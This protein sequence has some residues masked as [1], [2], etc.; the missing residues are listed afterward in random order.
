MF[1]FFGDVPNPHHANKAT[2]SLLASSSAMA[3]SSSSETLELVARNNHAAVMRE[4]RTFRQE[5]QRQ[6][7]ATQRH[8]S[9]LTATHQALQQKLSEMSVEL[10]LLKFNV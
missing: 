3:D 6:H 4:I 1:G 5:V 8:L 10:G 2:V 7:Q 9:E